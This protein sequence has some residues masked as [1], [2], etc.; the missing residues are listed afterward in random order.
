MDV[1]TPK[2]GKSAPR[3][4]L[5]FGLA[6]TLGIV[7]GCEHLGNPVVSAHDSRYPAHNPAPT[8][9]VTITGTVASTL[10]ITLTANY[11][12]SVKADC[13][14]SPLY[15]AGGFEGATIP[16]RVEVPIR[17]RPTGDRFTGTFSVDAFLPGKCD[18]HFGSVTMQVVKGKLVTAPFLIASANDPWKTT[19]YKGN[20]S[21]DAP[22]ILPCRLHGDIGYSCLPA[23][24][25]KHA[26][27]LIDTTTTVVATVLDDER[28]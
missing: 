12:G 27:V 10:G 19:E 9:T 21:S 25:V 1:S 2:N 16:L 28:K 18:W 14:V 6:V 26:Q 17:L 24:D 15:A 7:A 11:F 4:L 20:N 3:I 22:L 8:R 23:L 13:W 5:C